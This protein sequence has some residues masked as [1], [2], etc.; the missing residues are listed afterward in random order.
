MNTDPLQECIS[1]PLIDFHLLNEDQMF[2]TDNNQH[3]HSYQ[4]QD[5]PVVV[6][7]DI[8]TEYPEFSRFVKIIAIF[9]NRKKQ[10]KSYYNG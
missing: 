3:N 2:I 10:D 6:E 9:G 4:F 7:E 1:R 5:F 8:Q